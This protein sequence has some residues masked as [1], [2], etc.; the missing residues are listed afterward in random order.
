MEKNTK[1]WFNSGRGNVS[2]NVAK[3]DSDVLAQENETAA[4]LVDSKDN[5]AGRKPVYATGDSP[6]HSGRGLGRGQ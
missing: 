1:G 3:S 5:T 2:G 6:F 4:P